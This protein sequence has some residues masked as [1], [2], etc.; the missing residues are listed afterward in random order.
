LL[1]LAVALSGPG[2]FF[3]MFGYWAKRFAVPAASPFLSTPLPR[4]WLSL[5]LVLGPAYLLAGLALNIFLRG[6]RLWTDQRFFLLSLWVL[7]LLLFCSAVNYR[8][9]RYFLSAC[10]AIAILVGSLAAV[11]ANHS[12]WLARKLGSLLRPALVLVILAVGIDSA[13]ATV[14]AVRR[15][16]PALDGPAINARD[17]EVGL[18]IQR[19]IP[20]DERILASR[21]QTGYFAKRNYYL[22]QYDQDVAE[23]L[24]TISDP[25]N[26]ITVFVAD[27]PAMLHPS[28]SPEGQKQFQDYI[29]G[30]FKALTT[31]DLSVRLYQRTTWREEDSQKAVQGRRNPAPEE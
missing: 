16:V 2:D 4:Y 26:R 6:T 30:H 24:Q 12:T 3:H 28:I 9:Q 22:S 7:L 27:S 10:P 11:E 31:P 23:L 19:A 5:G 1:W 14:W 21:T 18:A 17:R 13:R 15:E 29:D 8:V 25:E 20:P